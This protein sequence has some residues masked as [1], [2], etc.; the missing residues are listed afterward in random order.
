M[1]RLVSLTLLQQLILSQL[2]QTQPTPAVKTTEYGLVMR[3]PRFPGKLQVKTSTQPKDS[4]ICS[5]NLLIERLSKLFLVSNRRERQTV[6][7]Q[8]E[9]TATGPRIMVQH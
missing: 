8:M 6:Q 3:W 4:M 9:I 2:Q 5:I 7:L 1:A